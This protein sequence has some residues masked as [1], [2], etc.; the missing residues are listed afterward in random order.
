[1]NYLRSINPDNDELLNASPPLFDALYAA[2][3]VVP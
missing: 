3:R 1:M 2:A